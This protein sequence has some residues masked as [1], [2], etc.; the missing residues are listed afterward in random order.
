M[1]KLVS[2]RDL[3]QAE[4]DLCLLHTLEDIFVKNKN[5]KIT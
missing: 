2:D 4:K 3:N 5:Q 1:P